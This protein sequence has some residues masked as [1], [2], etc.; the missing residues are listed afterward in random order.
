MGEDISEISLDRPGVNILNDEG[1]PLIRNYSTRA[2]RRW[3]GFAW[4]FSQVLPPT[5]PHPGQIAADSYSC[6]RRLRR[7]AG[8]G[9]SW[10][11]PQ[12]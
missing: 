7:A 10:K 8:A 6:A 5:R 11:K 1:Q 2:R 3:G 4:A 9:K 12:A